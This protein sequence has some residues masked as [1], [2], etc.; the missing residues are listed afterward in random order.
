MYMVRYR[1]DCGLSGHHA[2]ES[3]AIPTSSSSR[4]EVGY[5]FSYKPFLANLLDGESLLIVSSRLVSCVGRVGAG[6]VFPV[7]LKYVLAR[8]A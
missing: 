2:D 7:S 5:S 4:C 3:L 6:N 1:S 8:I